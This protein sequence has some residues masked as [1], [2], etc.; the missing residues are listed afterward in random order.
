MA[1]SGGCLCGAVRYKYT[2]DPIDAG[3]CQCVDCQKTSATGHSSKLAVLKTA[4]TIFGELKFYESQAESGG[5]VKR[6]FCPNCGSSIYSE[7]SSF[8]DLAAI[9]ATSLDDPTL[10]KPTKIVYASNGLSWDFMD[11]KLPQFSKMPPGWSK[12]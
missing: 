7:T 9:T 12:Q 10:F 1:F 8:P 6:G 5:I 3:H 11:P 2:A 4:L